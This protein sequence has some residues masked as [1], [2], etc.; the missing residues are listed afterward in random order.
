[1]WQ[2]LLASLIWSV[3]FGLI[4]NELAGVP[5]AGLAAMRLAIAAVLFLPFMRSA[6]LRVNAALV[7][8]GAV[9]FGV[10]SFMFMC[11]FRY[12]ESH[13]VVLFTVTTPIYVALISDAFRR[14]FRAVNL[15]AAL[16]SVAGAGIVSLGIPGLSLPGILL[17]QASCVCFA[18]GQLLYRELFVRSPQPLTDLQCFFWLYLG[19]FLCLLPLGLGNTAFVASMTWRQWLSLAFLAVM[20]S[21]VSYFLWNSGARKVSAGTLAVMNNLKI[22]LGV[23]V[24]LLIFRERMN[25]AGLA[26]GLLL[27]VVALWLAR[28]Q[29]E[30]S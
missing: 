13:E 16:V 23:L 27:M 10:M 8:I 18:L 21:G 24:S 15:C 26:A 29:K 20:G 4:G 30:P 28:F 2:L 3:S 5:P 17:I 12:L 9:Q 7:G 22:P 11:S 14:R 19:G 25:L 6:P 1:M